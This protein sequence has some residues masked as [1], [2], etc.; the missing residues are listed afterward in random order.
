VDTNGIITT[1]AG[2][3]SAGYSG[4]GY[5][6]TNASLNS[7]GCV[8]LD[9]NGNLFVGD[10]ARIRRV[11][12]NG[13]IT[14]VAGSA[15][16]GFSGDGGYATNA[17]LIGASGVTSDSRG[18]LFFADYGNNRI[19]K[20]DSNGIITTFA[21]MGSPFS[22]G[23][24]GPATNA[25]IVPTYVT[26]DVFGNILA[27]DNYGNSVREIDTNGIITTLIGVNFPYGLTVDSFDNL[28]IADSQNNRIG[29]FALL[30]PPI[31]NLSQVTTNNAG[32]YD[33]VIF[34]MNGSITSSVVSLTVNV[35]AYISSQ[36]A[37][38]SVS[39]NSNAIFSVSAGGTLPLSYQWLFNG[40]TIPGAMGSSFIFN[41]TDTNSTGMYSV[42]V[43]NSFGSVTSSMAKL[44]VV[45]IPAGIA[46]QPMS[47][48]IK[49]GS[50]LIMSVTASGSP[51]FSY[52]WFF[53]GV[54]MDS[55]TN[56][57]LS[58]PNVA[59][60]QAGRYS[61][62]VTSPYDS[63]TSHIA[64]LTVSEP[65][66]FTQ[67][68]TSQ[69]V[70][71]GNRALITAG[72]AGVG[73]L[74][75]QWQLN[76]TNLPNNLMSTVAGNGTN[77][78]SG[79]SG[80]ATTGKINEPNGLAADSVGNFFIA[81]TYNNRIR[82]VDTN[83]IMT[84]V[85][86]GSTAG[87]AGDGGP[88]TNARLYR[89]YGMAVDG[90]RNLFIADTYNHRIRKVDTNGL[91]TTVAGSANP[92]FSGDGGAATN[93]RLYYPYGITVDTDGNLFIADK[94]NYRI[95]KV[96]TNGIITTVA[97]KSNSG[98]SGDGGAATNASLN[99]PQGVALDGAG[100]LSIAD[101]NRVRKVDAYGMIT[102]V[103]GNGSLSYSGNNIVATNAGMNP[104]GLF[105][106]G[107]G[108]VLIADNAT[109]TSAR[110]ILMASSHC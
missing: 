10:N 6:A 4:D 52:Q 100:N 61:V 31:L 38:Q 9:A 108:D 75:F 89:C 23:D 11:D 30:G 105:V 88:A 95:R 51:P 39:V 87:F 86:G 76:G 96:D 84:T 7:P 68:P 26:A 72:V 16:T 12:T 85:A 29:K 69:S 65:P 41:V 79:D 14:T 59:T 54:A 56:A 13:I 99:S 37:N 70:L 45:I 103:A 49:Y 25:A 104:T 57:M 55:Q 82:K 98:F 62:L 8:A 101:Y 78:F 22:W 107:Y 17:A 20:V 63:I 46:S 28:Y 24:G 40:T 71:A 66:I 58:L 1:V 15:S 102:T 109:T 81:D 43:T 94:S 64:T 67:Q 91:I 18:N 53:N 32:N 3:G 47:Q 21:G 80:S 77:G 106:D 35:P 5:A 33:V 44:T 74:T 42:I 93:A 90:T 36:P 97:G 2:N 48:T 73:P 50:N 34:D 19:R 110:W 27:A 92:G 83:G 60:N